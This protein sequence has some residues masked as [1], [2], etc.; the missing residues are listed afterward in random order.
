[1]KNLFGE[2]VEMPEVKRI[3][4]RF[5]RMQEKYGEIKGF[6]CRDCEHYKRHSV[7]K[8]NFYKCELW[9]NTGSSASDIKLKETACRK[10]EIKGENK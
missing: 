10:F 3:G 9:L 5:I 8:S 7:G 6:Y 4:K 1:M 2:E